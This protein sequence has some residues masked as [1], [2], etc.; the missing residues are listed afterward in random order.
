LIAPLGGN[1]RVTFNGIE[2]QDCIHADPGKGEAVCLLR[3]ADGNVC[4]QPNGEDD[5]V[6]KRGEIV[7]LAEADDAPKQ[8][9]DKSWRVKQNG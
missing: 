4:K 8:Q 2:I 1:M 7:V 9:K 5:T 6:T 3:D